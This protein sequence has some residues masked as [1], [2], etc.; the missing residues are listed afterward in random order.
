MMDSSLAKVAQRASGF[1]L[2]L[3]VL[4]IVFGVL[5]IMLP[6]A[7]SLG[8][9]IVVA[10]LL[11]I[12][13]VVQGVHSFRC[14]G[15]G[16]KIWRL[17]VA[18]IYVSMGIYLRVNLHIGLA[19]LTLAMIIFCV[20]QGIFTIG[21][22]LMTRSSGASGWMLFDG[23]ITLILGIMIWRHWP[24][25]SFW[26]LGTFAGINMV[27]SGMSRLGLTLAVRRALKMSAQAA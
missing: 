19:A 25:S 4:L 9:V 14:E 13:G 5:A 27:V 7:M 26:V 3:S 15:I 24:A 6:V 16:S 11:I 12:S 18:L 1:S 21:A 17:L 2:V 20:S 23:F 8:V 22:Y 10:W